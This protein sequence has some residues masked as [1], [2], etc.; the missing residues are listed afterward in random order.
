MASF[1]QNPP[2]QEDTDKRPLPPP[3]NSILNANRGE[4]AVRIISTLKRLNIRSVAIYSHEDRKG[5]HVT[6]ADEAYPLEGNT[7][8]ST[9]FCSESIIKIAKDSG[10]SAVIPGYGF[11]SG[12]ADFAEACE[13][14]GLTWI[15]PTP[16]QMRSLGLKHLA[17]KLAQDA[18]GPLLPGTGLV[19]DVKTALAK[20]DAIGYP[21][22][23]KSSAGG[24][25]IGLTQ[26]ASP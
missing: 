26:C 25:G 16:Q 15:G 5:H 4:I 1:A 2:Q 10:A 13:V 7:V 3:F 21:I 17:R 23:V 8:K 22:I 12:S 9:Y 11:L 6:N 20:A 24:G 14:N 18:G 19:E